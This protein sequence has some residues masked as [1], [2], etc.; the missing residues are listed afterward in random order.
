MCSLLG[1]WLPRAGLGAEAHQRKSLDFLPPSQL[2]CVLS[3]TLCDI[4]RFRLFF[5]TDEPM[6][7]VAVL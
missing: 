1:C 3:G 6:T 5:I 2:D 4:D 7:Q